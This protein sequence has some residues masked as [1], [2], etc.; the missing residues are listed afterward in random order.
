MICFVTN[1]IMPGRRGGIG[2]FVEEAVSMLQQA[3]PGA[4]VLVTSAAFDPR[5]LQQHF[6]SIGLDAPV[7]SL[8]DFEDDPL[9]PSE[10]FTH[11]GYAVSYRVARALKRICRQF[12]VD[13]VEFLDYGGRGFVPIR[14]KRVTGEF[15]GQTLV[16][17]AH[18]T[19]ELIRDIEGRLYG[20]RGELLTYFM[21]RYAIRHA[22]LLLASTPSAL[23]EYNRYYHR[24]GSGMLSPLP[25][26]KLTPEPLPLR[27]IK[28]PP[29]RILWVGTCQTQKGVDVFAQA[30]V[31]LLAR[32]RRDVQ[33]TVM[34]RVFPTS[35]RYG[36]YQEEVRRSIP[37]EFLS[38]FEFRSE[39]Y[40]PDEMLQ[41]AREC[42]FAVVPSRWEAFCIVAHEL[43]WAGTPLILSPIGPF[44]DC[45]EEGKDAVFFDGAAE[46]LAEVMEDLLEGRLRLE[47]RPD[48]RSLYVES[49]EFAE[50][51]RQVAEL[52]ARTA[53][54]A[55]ERPLVS[56]IITQEHED[57][58]AASR[59]AESVRES[60]YPNVEILFADARSGTRAAA[61]NAAMQRSHGALLCFLREGDRLAEGYL[62][63]AVEALRRC[64][65][66]ACV[67]CFAGQTGNAA[68]RRPYG[69]DPVLI[70][71]EDGAGL[72]GAVL[73][74]SALDENQIRW[75]DAFFALEEWELAWSLAEADLEAEVI[76]R[77]GVQLGGE[78]QLPGRAAYHLTQQLSASHQRLIRSHPA[79][80]L[81]AHQTM[82]GPAGPWRTLRPLQDYRAL[83]LLRVGLKQALKEGPWELLRHLMRKAR[84]L[85]R[86]RRR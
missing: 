1:E 14:M 41:A 38:H 20:A 84:Q 40:G 73:R 63:L 32:G 64:P 6:R 72:R 35:P 78:E 21:E 68:R 24:D 28:P 50:V 19:A 79:R 3:G 11:N 56:V 10:R 62:P 30:G 22:D 16:V 23:E 86:R 7:F 37:E 47:G 25:V 54:E 80:I 77:I 45:F 8:S 74:R 58:A 2:F 26:R 57:G 39:Y 44:K 69:L 48:I 46:H 29:C 15:E 66:A 27:P 71:V 34:G 61:N 13:V 43:R 53:P 65:E 81:Q 49:D 60:G 52:P 85:F 36:S 76:P 12:P 9:P 67:S 33:F 18:G 51:Y 42:S 5:P 59:S 55:A 75:N 4:C 82:G 31:R 17:R 83:R 70:T